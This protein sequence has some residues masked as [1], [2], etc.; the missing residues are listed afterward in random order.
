MGRR[1][2]KVSLIGF[3]L[4]QPILLQAT[5]VFDKTNFLKLGEMMSQGTQMIGQMS[6]MQSELGMLNSV[7]GN[8]IKGT[9]MQNMGAGN[10]FLND[11]GS[12]LSDFSSPY[13]DPLSSLNN[14]GRN[15]FGTQDQSNYL[16]IKDYVKSKFF[17]NAENNPL[18]FQ[19]QDEIQAT[20]YDAV[21]QSTV[22]SMALSGQQKGALKKS[23]DQLKKL[24]RQTQ[25]DRTIQDEIRTTNQLLVVIANELTQQKAILAQL[26]ELKATSTAQHM[27][28]IVPKGA[29]SKRGTQSKGLPHGNSRG[30][31][32]LSDIFGGK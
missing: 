25:T 10:W 6:K 8:P 4:G 19:K 24:S 14:L 23:N 21:K 28:V 13:G 29:L 20:R 15:Q 26:L 32:S 12:V 18:S 16:F 3:L 22:D 1:I 11:F 9:V 17:N 5:A 7:L 30:S 31:T 27:P 2:L